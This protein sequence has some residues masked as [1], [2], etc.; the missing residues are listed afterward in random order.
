MEGLVNASQQ[1]LS[2][3]FQLWLSARPGLR[4][5]GGGSLDARQQPSAGPAKEGALRRSSQGGAD[6]DGG[7][8]SFPERNPKWQ[9]GE[10]GRRRTCSGEV[11]AP[12]WGLAAQAP[13]AQVRT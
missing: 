9:G 4:T 5:T 10:L 8:P 7:S 3:G 12:E 13:S 1:E 2:E 6:T 11:R